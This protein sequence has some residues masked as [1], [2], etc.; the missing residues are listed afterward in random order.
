VDKTAIFIDGG[1]MASILKNLNVKVD[2]LK[3]SNELCSSSERLR[4]YYY[5]CMPYQSNP[6]TQ[7]EKSRYSN[8]DKFIHNLKQKPRFEIRLGRLQKIGNDFFQKGVDVMLAV[9]LV[10]MSWD[11]QIQKAIVVASDSDFVYAV[12]TAKDAGIL[13]ELYYSNTN[14]INDSLLN[15]FD[16]RKL[17]DQ[18]LLNKC[19]MITT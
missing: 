3:L 6:P 8:A 10:K 7:E 9:D 1:Y 12:Q 11:K 15:V 18:N 2:F 5:H 13:T 14:P 17:I 19:K 16:E 4:T